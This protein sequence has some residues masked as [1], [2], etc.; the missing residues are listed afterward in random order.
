MSEEVITQDDRGHTVRINNSK[1]V[2]DYC[3]PR[4]TFNGRV[5]HLL[6]PK[7]HLTTIIE[8]N[9]WQEGLADDEEG[10][11]SRHVI[12]LDTELESALEVQ[13]R[14]LDGDL[15]AL[16]ALS[17]IHNHSTEFNL[18]TLGWDFR[19]AWPKIGIVL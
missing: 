14:L 17:W 3:G 19:C 12:L 6:E 10:L 5:F 13:R 8:Y 1:V 15:E 7:P 2:I 16:K 11:R 18:C 9:T 4:H